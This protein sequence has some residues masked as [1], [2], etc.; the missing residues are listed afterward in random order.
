MFMSANQSD[1]GPRHMKVIGD[2]VRYF[3][4]RFTVRWCGGRP[5]SQSLILDSRNLITA[6]AWLHSNP[7][8]EVFTAPLGNRC[9]ACHQSKAGLSVPTK[10]DSARNKIMTTIGEMSMPPS[11]GIQLRNGCNTGLTSIVINAVA[12][13]YVPGA[14]QL[15]MM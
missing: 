12:G 2:Q 14:T 3:L 6:G 4:V 1:S 13:L 8:Q 5:D 11:V 7:K 10:I 15:R 9:T